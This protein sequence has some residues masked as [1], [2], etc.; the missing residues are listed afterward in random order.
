MCFK[1]DVCK[2]VQILVLVP[3]ITDQLHI[4]SK[5][6]MENLMYMYLNTFRSIFHQRMIDAD[7]IDYCR[8]VSFVTMF[9]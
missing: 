1:V 2:R 9:Q 4:M 5:Q 3:T 8:Q 6:A 7:I